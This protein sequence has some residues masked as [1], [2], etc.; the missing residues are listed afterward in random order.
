MK[1]YTS[2]GP[3]PRVVRMFMAEKGIEVPIEQVDLMRGE[4][5]QAAH[6]SRNPAGQTPVLDSTT[7]ASLPRSVRSASTSMKFGPIPR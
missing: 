2:I 6:L 1:L 3:N 5:R 4:N 7:A